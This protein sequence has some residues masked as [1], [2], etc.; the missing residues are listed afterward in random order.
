[1]SFCQSI[2]RSRQAKRS[3][4]GCV[5]LC[6]ARC[7]RKRCC[8]RIV[9]TTRIGSGSL[10]DRKGY[11]QTFRP[12]EIAKTRSAS[13][14]ISIVRA[15]SSSGSSTRSSTADVSRPDMTSS[16]PT[17]WHSLNSHQS[18]FGCALMSPRS[19]QMV[20]LNGGHAEF[21]IGRASRDPVALP[22]LHSMLCTASG[23]RAVRTSKHA[24]K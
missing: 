23:T 14:R 2:S 12:S 20:F 4:I 22:T 5:R 17:I 15:I 9:D 13:A 10:L 18:E 8:S 16:Q 1:M 7:F 6:S 24:Y 3:T 21:T 19:S 11:G